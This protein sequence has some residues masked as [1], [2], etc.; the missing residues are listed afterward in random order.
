MVQPSG[1]EPAT[2]YVV[3]EGP[4]PIGRVEAPAGKPVLGVGAETV[5]LRR[6]AGVARRDAC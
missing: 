1:R 5:L 2:V 3:L 4:R 6:D